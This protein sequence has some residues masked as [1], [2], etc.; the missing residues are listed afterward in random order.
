MQKSF[1]MI[2]KHKFTLLAST[3]FQL[4]GLNKKKSSIFSL[5]EILRFIYLINFFSVN[6]TLHT[7]TIQL[8][9]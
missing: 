8:M 6:D 4:V 9:A 1:I 2:L 7:N 3:E 5:V